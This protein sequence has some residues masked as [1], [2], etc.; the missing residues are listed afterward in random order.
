MQGRGVRQMDVPGS[1]H[2]NAC[3]DGHSIRRD[4]RL[5][6]AT[7][8]IYHLEKALYLAHEGRPRGCWIDL[9][10]DVQAASI[11]P[12]SLKPLDPMECAPSRIRQR[13]TRRWSKPVGFSQQLNCRPIL[14]A[15][16]GIRLAGAQI[17][18][19][20]LVNDLGIPVLT[21]WPAMDLIPDN[22][23]FDW[24]ARAAG[25]AWRELRATEFKLSIGDWGA[26]PFGAHRLRARKAGAS[27]KEDHGGHRPG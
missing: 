7:I 24:P 3:A 8:R 27:R 11:D 21:T 19:L 9:P 6:S 5:D 14:L 23:A 15:G 25:S 22:T 2:R 12:S 20:E 17:E 1:G 26:P 18:F 10:L 16:S 13:S 4:G